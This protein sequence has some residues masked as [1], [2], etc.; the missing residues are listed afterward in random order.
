MIIEKKADAYELLTIPKKDYL[1][2]KSGANEY[3]I[4]FDEIE[5]LEAS[6]EYIKYWTKGRYYM[7]LGAL[8]KLKTQL[9]ENQFIQV[10]RSFIVPISAIKGRE[11]YTLLLKNGK[12]I[13]IGKTYRQAVLKRLFGEHN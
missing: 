13:S 5:L 11:K 2:I 4:A 1:H 8:K 9:P 6:S 10:H 12:R 7:V 3:K